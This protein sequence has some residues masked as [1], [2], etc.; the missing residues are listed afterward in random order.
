MRIKKTKAKGYRTVLHAYPPV[1]KLDSLFPYPG[2]KTRLAYVIAAFIPPAAK[3]VEPFAG[4]GSVTA[5]LSA[6]IMADEDRRL[7]RFHIPGFETRP[8]MYILNDL[9]L[10]IVNILYCLID[11]SQFD[12]LIASLRGYA[13]Q[14]TRSTCKRA[15]KR[16]RAKEISREDMPLP[17]RAAAYIFAR[18]CSWG[19]T[20]T[21]V[22]GDSD[23]IRR[24]SL[25]RLDIVELYHYLFNRGGEVNVIV[26]HDDA[27]H[28]AI[29]HDSKNTVTYFDPPYIETEQD[30]EA[31]LQSS[32]SH[33]RLVDTIFGLRGTW[34]ISHELHPFYE[35]AFANKG[36]SK[37]I[38]KIRHPLLR[39]GGLRKVEYRAE[40]IYT[41]AD[42]NKS[43]LMS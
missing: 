22:R 12:S 13:Q 10:E 28:A 30:Y 32:A 21:G 9:S 40:V 17:S 26:S 20:G 7:R 8:A 29:E 43:A 2:N 31:A 15:Q 14:S 35:K 42:L 36:L 18:S 6:I 37:I 33:L 38:H 19:G 27:I 39:K 16:I 4:T 23:L 25:M 34:F 11:P 41:N 1:P 5:T 24:T 3:F